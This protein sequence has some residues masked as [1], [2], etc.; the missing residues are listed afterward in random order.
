MTTTQLKAGTKT[1]IAVEALT[2]RYGTNAA[3]DS[4]SSEVPAGQ[5]IGLL[6]PNGAGK[7]TAMKMLLGLVRPTSGKN[8]LPWY[9]AA[10]GYRYCPIGQP[11]TR[12]ARRAGPT[13]STQRG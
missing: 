11:G 1:V 9:E 10:P 7:T 12:G 3:V 2:Q 4:L 5:V 6:G 8:V 13:A